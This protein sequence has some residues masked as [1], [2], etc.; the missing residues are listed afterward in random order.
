M[1]QLKKTQQA[2]HEGCICPKCMRSFSGVSELLAHYEKCQQKSPG[3]EDSGGGGGSGRDGL[4]SFLGKAKQKLL[5]EPGRF[6][7]TQILNQQLLQHQQQ[8]QNQKGGSQEK[9]SPTGTP[10]YFNTFQNVEVSGVARSHFDDFRKIRSGR[11]ERYAS[12]AN[13]LK[14]RLSKLVQGLEK[15]PNLL[16]KTSA[17]GCKQNKKNLY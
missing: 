11:L 10:V 8:Q 1:S 4:K 13:K 2:I 15:Y 16:A 7:D 5:S 6:L 3:L 9:S 14:I 17:S 12:E